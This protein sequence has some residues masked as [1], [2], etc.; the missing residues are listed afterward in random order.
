MLS[1]EFLDISGEQIPVNKF[2]EF[3]GTTYVFRIKYN[4]AGDFFTIEVYDSL[5]TT[6][7]FSNKIVYGSNLIDSLR[8][9]FADKIIPLNLDILQG[10]TSSE[11]ITTESLGAAVK[12]YTNIEEEA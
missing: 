10:I 4:E 1:I 6:F 12:L 7:L 11:E 3:S 2:Y 5:D 8:A 9:P